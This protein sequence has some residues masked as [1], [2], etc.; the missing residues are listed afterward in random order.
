M[1]M[2]DT[3]FP[4]VRT[5]RFVDVIQVLLTYPTRSVLDGVLDDVEVAHDDDVR[6][7]F[8]FTGA[9]RFELN[10]LFW[11]ENEKDLCRCA[12]FEEGK[13]LRCNQIA[14]RKADGGVTRRGKI[15]L[16]RC[17]NHQSISANQQREIDKNEKKN[18][19]G[20]DEVP[21]AAP[22]EGIVRSQSKHTPVLLRPYLL[23]RL[24]KGP[25]AKDTVRFRSG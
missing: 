21:A 8:Q 13:D 2:K 20:K 4:K 16:L 14:G 11:C 7:G 15:F 1:T 23:V 3:F 9:N 12:V 25:I 24:Y 5:K 19:R 17:A 18:R 10:K 6:A 22:L